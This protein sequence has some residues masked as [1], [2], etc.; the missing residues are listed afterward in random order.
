MNKKNR[1]MK[2]YAIVYADG[3]NR[4]LTQTTYASRE[5][6]GDAL[7][8]YINTNNAGYQKGDDDYL[9]PFNFILVEIESKD[10]N[11]LVTD[12]DSAKKVLDFKL[13]DGL[14][15]VRGSAG[16]CAIDAK[17]AAW[18]VRSVDNENLKTLITLNKLF[19]L[20]RAWNK[21]DGFV[22][23]FLDN[24]QRKYYPYFV[25]DSCDAKHIIVN[26]SVTVGCDALCLNRIC[27]KSEKRALQFGKQFINLFKQV[28]L[29]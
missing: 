22:P 16:R 12:F 20:A 19:T 10:V 13:N 29:K 24:G 4:R 23:K 7:M 14:T 11:E 26:A 18:L 8:Y 1:K 5:E 2:K 28:L 21:V 25:R 15:L 27:F 6:A 9:N 17:K 3:S